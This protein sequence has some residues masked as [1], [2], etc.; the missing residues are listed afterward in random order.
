MPQSGLAEAFQDE[1]PHRA[2]EVLKLRGKL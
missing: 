1:I 2:T